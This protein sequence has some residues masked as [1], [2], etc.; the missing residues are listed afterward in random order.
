MSAIIFETANPSLQCLF[1]GLLK[2]HLRAKVNRET[3]FMGF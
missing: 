3:G 1:F 2:S